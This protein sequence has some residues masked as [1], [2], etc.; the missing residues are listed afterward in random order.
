MIVCP[1]ISDTFFLTYMQSFLFF[2]KK[3]KKEKKKLVAFLYHLWYLGHF[4]C[5]FTLSF[6]VQQWM[7]ANLITCTV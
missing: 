4:I 5:L 1:P 2:F 6:G 3:K 7:K